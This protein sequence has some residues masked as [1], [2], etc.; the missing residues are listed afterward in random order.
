VLLDVSIVA[1][2]LVDPQEGGVAVR[3]MDEANVVRSLGALVDV[4]EQRMNRHFGEDD[5]PAD[6]EG[7]TAVVLL[8]EGEMIMVVC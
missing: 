6:N 2:V 8:A 7:L 4:D 5:Q 3:N 1:A